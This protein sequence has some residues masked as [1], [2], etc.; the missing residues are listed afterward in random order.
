MYAELWSRTSANVLHSL[1]PIKG[2]PGQEMKHPTSCFQRGNIRCCCSHT[3]R[4]FQLTWGNEQKEAGKQEENRKS[5][6]GFRLSVSEQLHNHG[7]GKMGQ[8]CPWLCIYWCVL[9][10]ETLAC[11]T[12]EMLWKHSFAKDLTSQRWV[13]GV[14]RWLV[15]F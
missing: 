13:I 4:G 10:C 11:A 8:L 7:D 2:T 12:I 1:P 15:I 9:D 5:L 3:V 6:H 14:K